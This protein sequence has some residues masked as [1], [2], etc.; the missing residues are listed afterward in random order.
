MPKLI[1]LGSSNSIPDE[2]H[3]NTHM[4]LLGKNSK[5][6]IDCPNNPI[7]RLQQVNINVFDLTD[8][9]LTHFHP[10][11]VSGLPLLLMDMWLM[12]RKKPINIYGL[13]YTL[14]RIEKLMGLFAWENWPDFYPIAFNYISGGELVP[15]LNNDEFTIESSL[16]NHMIPCMGLRINIKASGK[17]VAYSSDTEPCSQVIRMA[18]KADFL[19]HEAT[20]LIHGHSSAMQAGDI[21]SQAEVKVLYLI[22]YPT[23]EHPIGKLV[24]EAGLRFDGPVQLAEDFLSLDL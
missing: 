15:L 5:I 17:V 14:E 4:V 13:H 9:I 6:L 19:F 12:G 22:H 20:G 10:D 21:A 7:I 8:I 24:S 11:H 16:V 3:D 1:I 23:G 18:E 2:K